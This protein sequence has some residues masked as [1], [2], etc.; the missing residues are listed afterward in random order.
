VALALVGLSI[1]F[2]HIS[3]TDVETGM[4]VALGV[5]TAAPCGRPVNGGNTMRHR[6]CD[7]DKEK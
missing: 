2:R 1:S 7:T 3:L 5:A 4:F 6:W